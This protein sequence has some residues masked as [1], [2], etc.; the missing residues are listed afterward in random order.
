M[1][2][3]ATWS[4]LMARDAGYAPNDAVLKAA[5]KQTASLAKEGMAKTRLDYGEPSS[6]ALAA[7]VLA[8]GGDKL[9]AAKV[10][11]YI[12]AHRDENTV[13]NTYNWTGDR[14]CCIIA[15]HD[16]GGAYAAKASTWME[17][18]WSRR[19][20]L[21]ELAAWPVE[22]HQESMG[23]AQPGPDTGATAW[24]MIAAETISPT[25]PRIDSVARWIMAN[26]T[27][28]YWVSP[29]TTAATLMALGPYI[30]ASH[31]REPNFDATV[32]VNGKVVKTQHF[33]TA[34]LAD[35]DV[36]FDIAG[37]DLGGASTV[38][39]QKVGQGRLYYSLDLRQSKS[40]GSIPPPIPV[41]QR[42]YD[43]VW[44]PERLE[45]P[46]EPSGYRITRVY[47][48]NTSRRNAIWEDTVPT[49]SKDYQVNDDVIV[50]LIIDATH[51]ASH[52]IVE[53]PVPAGCTIGEVSS[54]AEE[55]WDSWWDF[56]DVRDDKIVFFIGDLTRGRHEIDYHLHASSPGTYDVMPTSITGTFD[57]TLHVNGRP[58]RVTVK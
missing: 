25:D 46:F 39:L 28:D 4:L 31:E 33:G 22:P 56:T 40:V 7:I 47:L 41:W 19:M 35:P 57:P 38:H 2:T 21:G 36:S 52:L 55:S 8:H 42:W 50:R 49:R 26:R 20:R 13:Y 23:A 11:D 27:G 16:I 10:V 51:A 29:G 6:L 43:R 17:D 14:A 15:A 3:Y 18:L 12:V 24:A 30:A 53:E 54:D 32:T 48:R 5:I 45:P 34:S 9:T 1:T 58:N 37:V 44:H